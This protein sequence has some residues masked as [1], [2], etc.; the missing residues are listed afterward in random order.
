[1]APKKCLKY[2]RKTEDRFMKG[3]SKWYVDRCPTKT[4]RIVESCI[5]YEELIYR[6][7]CGCVGEYDEYGK[8]FYKPKLRDFMCAI[9][10][11]LR[12]VEFPKESLNILVY[13]DFQKIYDD[14]YYYFKKSFFKRI[15]I[16]RINQWGNSP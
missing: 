13:N 14:D 5:A 15:E 12:Y 9:Y 16:K 1:M 10:C 7:A 11:K 8:I 2:L 4:V 3:I 6:M